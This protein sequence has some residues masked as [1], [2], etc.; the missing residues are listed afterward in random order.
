VVR[1]AFVSVVAFVASMLYAGP[2]NSAPAAGIPRLAHVVVI[3]FENH[4]RN[5]IVGSAAAPTF[6]R[7]ASMYAQATAYDAVAHPSLPNYLALVSGS[8]HGVTDDCTDCPQS[9]LT[10]GSQLSASHR[11]WAAFAE[12]YPG[13]SRFA[14]KHV[15]FLYFPG[16]ASHVLPLQ[17]LDPRRLPAYALVI[18]DLCHDMHD[19]PVSTGDHWLRNVVTP[20]LTSKDTAIFIV[21]DEGTSDRGGGGNVALIVVGTVVRRHATFSAAMSHYGLLRTIETALG[22]PLLGHARAATLLT[23]IWR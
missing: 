22:L 12:G 8:T 18:P 7:L 13:S 20:L 17:R 23:G 1:A 14:K 10:I 6:T 21:F 19:C 2:T 15:P 4:E 3:V 11:S 16:G 5:E 9:G